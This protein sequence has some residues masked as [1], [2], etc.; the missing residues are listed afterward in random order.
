M[1]LRLTFTYTNTCS[2][3]APPQR[4]GNSISNICNVQ[5]KKLIILKDVVWHSLQSIHDSEDLFST[6]YTIHAIH[7]SKYSHLQWSILVLN[8]SIGYCW[9]DACMIHRAVCFSRNRNWTV[10]GIHHHR[11][12]S[13]RQLLDCWFVL[14]R[15][16]MMNG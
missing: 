16:A 15:T 1:T 4:A 2:Q 10:H 12:Y 11:A 3:F 7:I 8:W 14:K 9:F 5:F 13:T 6:P